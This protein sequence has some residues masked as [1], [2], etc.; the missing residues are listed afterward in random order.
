MN[1]RNFQIFLEENE[2]DPIQIK[3][4]LSKLDVYETYLAKDNLNLDSVNPNKLST[5]QMH[6]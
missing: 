3:N 5:S 2:I 4:Y 6:I 1:T